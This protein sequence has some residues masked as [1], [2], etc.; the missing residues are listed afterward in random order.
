[1]M[2]EAG[3]E[4]LPSERFRVWT[5]TADGAPVTVQIFIA[6]GGEVTYW[7]GGWDPEWSAL[8]P[9]MIGICAGVEDAFARGERRVDFGE[10]EHH[11]KTRLADGDDEIAWFV[12]YPRGPGYPRTLVVTAPARAKGLARSALARLPEPVRERVGRLRGRGEEPP[13]E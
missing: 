9:A 11:Y 8:S 7:N 4:L 3:R 6:A 1:M 13:S 12:L 2:L 5:I 10:G